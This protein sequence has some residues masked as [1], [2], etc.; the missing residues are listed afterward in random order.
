M[1][2]SPCPACSINI[3]I[4]PL[5]LPPC[6]PPLRAGKTTLLRLIAGLE[7]PT[8]GQVLFDGTDITGLG[9]QDRELGFV[10][11]VGSAVGCILCTM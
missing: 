6:P 2:G 11:Q 5:C 1:P 7:E 9:V 8:A 4:L 10:F 3:P